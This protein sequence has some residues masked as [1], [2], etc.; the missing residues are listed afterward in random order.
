MNRIPCFARNLL[1]LFLMHMQDFHPDSQKNGR[2]LKQPIW[3]NNKKVL[4]IANYIYCQSAKKR[5]KIRNLLFK[6][7][8][9][10]NFW[11]RR[12]R[13]AV[14][15]NGGHVLLRPAPPQGMPPKIVFQSFDEIVVTSPCSR[16]NLRIVLSIALFF[17]FQ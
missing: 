14:G 16:L 7:S 15:L 8:L 4:C 17:N 2:S 5:S 3:Y 12:Y 6:L 9:L 10:Q 11:R 1:F 13:G